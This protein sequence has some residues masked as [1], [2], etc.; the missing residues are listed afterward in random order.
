MAIHPRRP[1]DPELF[2]EWM[3]IIKFHRAPCRSRWTDR[4]EGFENTH[5]YFE[6]IRRRNSFGWLPIFSNKNSLGRTYPGTACKTGNAYHDNECKWA[7]EKKSTSNTIGGTYYDNVQ[8]T[9]LKRLLVNQKTSPCE[10]NAISQSDIR[11]LGSTWKET[12][13]VTI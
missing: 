6:P 2:P 3:K 1:D 5:S 11:E 9:D 8:F 7:I 13:F 10:M 4:N 12:R